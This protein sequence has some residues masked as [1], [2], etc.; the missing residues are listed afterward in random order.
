MTITCNADYLLID[1]NKGFNQF[2]EDANGYING[3]TFKINAKSTIPFTF[4]QTDFD[5]VIDSSSFQ[6]IESMN[7]QN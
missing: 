1:L 7:C 3:I 2:T 5:K 6:I 4:Y